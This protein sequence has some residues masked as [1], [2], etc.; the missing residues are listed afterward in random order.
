MRKLFMAQSL[1]ALSLVSTACI[2]T[3]QITAIPTISSAPTKMQEVQTATDLPSTPTPEPN[4]QTPAV[5][6]AVDYLSGQ[7]GVSAELISVG[8]VEPVEWIN[9][10]LGFPA[11]EEA[12]AEMITAG[13]RVSL[14]ANGK[15]YDLHTNSDGSTV[16]MKALPSKETPVEVLKASQLLAT[17]LQVEQ[18]E[19]TLVSY[20]EHTWPD[21]CMGRMEPG[22]MCAQVITTGYEITFDVYGKYVICTISS[23]NHSF[24]IT[25]NPFAQTGMKD[26]LIVLDQK[27]PDCI[28][29]MFSDSEVTTGAC[30]G[31]LI[32]YSYLD[33]D[34]WYQLNWLAARYAPFESQI[35]DYSVRFSSRGAQIAS[36][37]E[38][39]S[40]LELAKIALMTSQQKIS[41]PDAGLV[42]IIKQTGGL[43]GVCTQTTLHLDGWGYRADCS[44]RIWLMNRIT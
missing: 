18:G 43:A 20:V 15:D 7:L 33:P 32:S 35:E 25:T 31:K 14:S 44:R 5:L 13:Y 2:Q 26:V 37:A 19:V 10:C 34:Y 8:F 1:L 11:P 3:G 22:L 21:A 30:G 4:D 28:S 23:R 41:G 38:Q 9:S 27:T 12:C 6:A 36:P 29:A 24:Q 42:A 16:R 40:I 17:K 39:R